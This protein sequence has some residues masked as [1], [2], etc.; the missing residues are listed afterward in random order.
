MSIISS[1]WE[2]LGYA[3]IGPI[4]PGNAAELQAAKQL[5]ELFKAKLDYDVINESDA[6]W[7]RDPARK[8]GNKRPDASV[9]IADID[10]AGLSSIN[11][12]KILS[13][14][15]HSRYAV[16]WTGD[17]ASLNQQIRPF[18]SGDD[19]QSAR[20]AYDISFSFLS[21]PPNYLGSYIISKI[22]PNFFKE[23]PKGR[24]ILIETNYKFESRQAVIRAGYTAT[25]Y[26][27]LSNLNLK[28][29]AFK[30]LSNWQALTP[31][32]VL[33]TVLDLGTLISF[34]RIH[35]FTASRPGLT[36]VFIFG[37]PLE[38]L[39][40]EFP[41][42]WMESYGSRWDFARGKST[43]SVNAGTVGLSQPQ[44]AQ[45]RLV[46]ATNYTSNDVKTWIEFLVDTSNRYLFASTDPTQFRKN[47]LVDFVT[48]FEHGLSV[49]RLIRMSM[50]S[51]TSKQVF[52]RK[53]ATMEC[54]D[55]I[56]ELR[57]YWDSSVQSTDLFKI[58][59]NPTSGLTLMTNVLA[60]LPQPFKKDLTDATSLAYDHLRSGIVGSIFVPSKITTSGDILVRNRSLAAEVAEGKDEFT[61]NVVRALRNTHHGYMTEKDRSARPS[62][63]LAL[64]TGDLPDTFSFLGGI[65][66]LSIL[67]D[68]ASLIGRQDTLTGIYE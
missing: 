33:R 61:A 43:R 39:E 14:Y 10:T 44:L 20:A 12:E 37:T 41:T 13:N 47:S 32:N 54:A 2:D 50:S 3:K 49:D 40:P 27:G 18:L 42:S 60:K 29:D 26:G 34:P 15:L 16:N 19:S 28:N 66:G 11:I 31:Y 55:I 48:C 57:T 22:S 17:P 30:A 58:L 36:A 23:F 8:K 25:Q 59:F 65:F 6:V 56:D 63:Y 21:C 46:Q 62:R 64:V 45:R 38:H 51:I 68:P 7:L 53:S 1:T 67:V 52:S 4:H 24:I 35:F 5:G 9:I